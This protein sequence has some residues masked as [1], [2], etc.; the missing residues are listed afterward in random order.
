MKSLT[1]R[2]ETFENNSDMVATETQKKSIV[3][4]TQWSTIAHAQQSN[5]LNEPSTEWE[6]PLEVGV[7]A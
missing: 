2:E 1:E 3:K 7:H 6:S 4:D 5:P